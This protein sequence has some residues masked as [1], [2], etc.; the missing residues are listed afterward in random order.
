MK[1]P[2]GRWYDKHPELKQLLDVLKVS[3]ISELEKVIGGMKELIMEHDP[4][5][6]DRWV[7]EFPLTTKRR[8]YDKDPYSW[9]VINSLK[10]ADRGLLRGVI[11]YL[12]GE[13]KPDVE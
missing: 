11:L 1:K 5:L 2:N 13:L 9:L 8:W 7:L 6:M 12:K 4:E 3:Q 10:Y